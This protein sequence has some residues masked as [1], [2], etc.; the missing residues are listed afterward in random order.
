MFM[1]AGIQD[2][3]TFE[4]EL[5]TGRGHKW[6]RGGFCSINKVLILDLG[7]S[8]HFVKSHRVVLLYLVCFSFYMLDFNKYFYEREDYRFYQFRSFKKQLST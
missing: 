6:G 5:L 2:I 7:D 8:F 3:G 1:T 4:R